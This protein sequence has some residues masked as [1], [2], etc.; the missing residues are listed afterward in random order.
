M[1]VLQ[2]GAPRDYTAARERNNTAEMTSGHQE[3]QSDVMHSE[4]RKPKFNKEEMTS[5]HNK[6]HN[7]VMHSEQRNLG[8][9]D[10]TYSERRKLHLAWLE[11][12]S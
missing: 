4:R 9:N 6:G 10:V 12:P 7:D 5:R 3:G 11:Q 8:S 1:R 2:E